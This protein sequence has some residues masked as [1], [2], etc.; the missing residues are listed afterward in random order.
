MEELLNTPF[1]PNLFNDAGITNV[2]GSDIQSRKAPDSMLLIAL[3]NGK[4]ASF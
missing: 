4:L 3:P 2:S 1:H